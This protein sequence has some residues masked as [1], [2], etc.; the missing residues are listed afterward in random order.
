M[1]GTLLA[2]EIAIRWKFSAWPFEQPDVVL[3]WL[4][5]KDKTLRWR[6][7]ANDGRNSLGLRNEEV[8]PKAPGSVRILF[9]G[10]SLVWMGET[11]SGP[12]YTEVIED[13]LNDAVEGDCSIDV[14]NAG[15]LAYTTYQELQFLKIYGLDMEPDVVILGFVLNDVYYKYL[16]R[17][18]GDL[19]LGPLP[20]SNLHAFD[21]HR[22]PGAL[23]ARSYLAH[24]TCRAIQ[25]ARR[26]SPFPFDSHWGLYLAWKPYG[27]HDTRRLIREMAELLKARN[28]P[29]T[30][31]VFPIRDQVDETLLALDREYVLY[32][33]TRIVGI[34]SEN[35]VPVLDLTTPLCEGGGVALYRDYLHL[36]GKGNDI[37]ADQITQHLMEHRGLWQ[38]RR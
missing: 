16:Q 15:V 11:S 25:R 34:C 14:I 26:R 36:D 24:H 1:I 27:W 6:F 22:L 38:A 13:R 3:P 33:Q 37:V 32:P 5:E 2:G 31:V 19:A 4:T 9:L 17:P 20:S 23:L 30:V 12:L 7:S 29:L 18:L 28:I 35:D 8:G 10:D 21:T